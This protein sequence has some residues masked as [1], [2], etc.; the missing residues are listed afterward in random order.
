MWSEDLRDAERLIHVGQ[1]GMPY[2][3]LLSEASTSRHAA[4]VDNQN[5]LGSVFPE[6]SHT[7]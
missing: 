7:P 6:G 1:T 3:A 5:R 2:A 4:G